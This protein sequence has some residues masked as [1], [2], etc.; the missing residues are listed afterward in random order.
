[1][2]AG[3]LNIGKE[4]EPCPYCGGIALIGT[5]CPKSLTCRTCQAKPGSPCMRPSGHKAMRLHVDR[6]ND[7]ERIDRE[8]TTP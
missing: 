6:I 7:A 8:A 5:T 4:A 2:T 1:M 3:F